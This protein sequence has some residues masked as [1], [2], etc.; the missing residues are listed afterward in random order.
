MKTPKITFSKVVRDKVEGDTFSIFADNVQ[1]GRFIKEYDDA[2]L[3]KS[4]G[5]AV[6]RPI[7]FVERK[8]FDDF[9]KFY[10]ETEFVRNAKNQFVRFAKGSPELIVQAIEVS[11]F[12]AKKLKITFG[13]LENFESLKEQ[14]FEVYANGH[15]LGYFFKTTKKEY[16]RG[17][18]L[19]Y[20]VENEE[21]ETKFHNCLSSNIKETKA[22]FRAWV[23]I[24]P[25][26][27]YRQ[28]GL[29]W[30]GWQS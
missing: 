29:I 3:V 18:W 1:I 19:P 10:A 4:Q 8:F 14:T 7:A 11:A 23:E 26:D 6:W 15:Y 9:W 30:E 17:I 25:E 12:R 13:K 20:F 22:G 24:R 28:I 27:V 5:I 21:L 16:G 2:T